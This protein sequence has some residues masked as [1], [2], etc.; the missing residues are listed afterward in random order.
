MKSKSSPR[1]RA[2]GRANRRLAAG[3]KTTEAKASPAL[4][5]LL[6]ES[7]E[8][9]KAL[10]DA[11]VARFKPADTYELGLVAT[12]AACTWQK[13]RLWDW[14]AAIIDLEIKRSAIL[15]PA[16]SALPGDLQRALAMAEQSVILRRMSQYQSSLDFRW[17]RA[18]KALKTS[19]D[20]CAI[21]SMQ[22][23]GKSQNRTPEKGAGSNGSGGP[24][25]RPNQLGSSLAATAR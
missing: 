6:T 22:N 21:K 18:S 5:A 23:E 14:E 3:H 24:P 16:F 12:I 17:N 1:R 20:G 11:Y 10:R 19:Q 8:K 15:D 2:A 25:S 9:F 7:A 13:H 4:N